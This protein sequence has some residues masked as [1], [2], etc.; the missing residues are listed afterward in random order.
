MSKEYLCYT[1]GGCDNKSEDG[2]GSSAWIVF[3]DRKEICR[4]SFG[5]VNTTNNRCELRAIIGAVKEIP[6][7][8]KIIIRTDS[9]YCILVLSS[10][11]K[12][13]PKNMDLVNEFRELRNHMRS[14]TFQWVKG[15]HGD[16]FNEICD[17]MCSDMIEQVRKSNFSFVDKE[18]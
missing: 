8:S 10:I 5:I 9:Q 17:N 16:K 15:H 11:D 14:I 4:K 7:G 2:E 6:E 3:H 12:I 13:Y 1:D 18:F